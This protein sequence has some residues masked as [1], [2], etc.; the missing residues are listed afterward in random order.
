MWLAQVS[1]RNPVFATMMMMAFV[2]LGLFSYQRLHVDQFPQ[3]DFPVVV[4]TTAYPGAAPE[5]VESEVTRLIEEQVNTI[6]GI[7]NLTS[8]SYEGQSVVII[9]FELTVDSSRAVQDVREKVA[10]VK[11]RFRDE[12]EEPGI[13][14]F[15][16]ADVPIISVAVTSSE[17]PIRELTTL[18]DQVIKKRLENVPGV[19][20]VTLVGG[21]KREIKVALRPTQMQ[22]LGISTDQVLQAIRDENAEYPAGTLTSREQEQVVQIEGRFERPADFERLVVGRR[23][24]QAVYLGQ[25][26]TVTDGSQEQETLALING[27][28]TLAFDVLKAQDQN[29]I[30]VADGIKQ[31]VQSLQAELGQDVQMQVI[32]DAS[33]AIRVGVSNVQRTLIEGA[34]LT[35]IIVFLFLNSW[36]STVITG[37]TLP[38]S[39]IGTFLF[40]Y[41]FGFTLNMLTLMALSLCV[42]LLIDDAIVVRENIVRHAHMGKSPKQAAED[43]TTEI[44]LAVL[45][46]T[47]SIVAVFLPVGFMGGIIGRFFFQFGITVAAA[48]LISLF[49]SF[50]LDPMLSSIWPDPASHGKTPGGPIGR[51]LARFAAFTDAITRFYQR[52]LA[53]SLK[54]RVATVLLAVG[55]FLGSFALVPLL[56]TE[57]LPQGHYAEGVVQFQTPVGSSLEYTESKAR[58][59]TDA[60]REFPEVTYVYAT[61]NAGTASGKNNANAFLQLKDREERQRGLLELKPLIRER[62]NRING[63][64]VTNVGSASEKTLQASLQGPNLDELARYNALVQERLKTIPG[65]VDLD[66]SLKPAKP[67]IAVRIKREAAADVGVGVAQ[68][69]ALLRPLLAGDA[70][71]AWRGPDDEYYDVNVRLDKAD[72]TSLDDLMQLSVATTQLDANG[73]PR[74]VPLRQIADLVPSVGPSQIN[75]RAL[76]REVELTA[77]VQG[78]SAG[79]VANDVAAALAEIPWQPGYHAT[80]GGSTRDMQESFGYA[81]AALG[82]AVVFI[83]MI[84]A[85]QFGSFLQP[86]AIMSSLPLTLIGVFASLLLFGSTLNILSIIGFIMLMG[87]VTKNA[88]L[89]IDFINHARRAG[90]PRHDAILE[91]AKVRLRPILMTTLAMIFGMVPLALGLGEGSEQSAPMGQAVI[92]GIITSSVLTLVV[93]PVIY[94]YLDDFA[95]RWR[96][97][98]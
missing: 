65:L 8:R 31:A 64:T 92:G 40:M 90:M 46:T 63:V 52:L 23:G 62:L 85:S 93:V 20:Q 47:F 4:V 3:I 66:S 74:T 6:S 95:A 54:H 50:T 10:V 73:A 78:R 84:L 21:I 14:R 35:V 86:L 77:N 13:S 82:L 88:I 80:I 53:W 51:V 39:I 57:F 67:T 42:G 24:G 33:R 32:K 83:Y 34:V 58:Q 81:L 9:E 71:S 94:T 98:E 16:P 59:V 19:G 79:D 56:G 12:I 76:N 68:V 11:P 91:A 89:L 43:G 60:L 38:I 97:H 27:Q 30:L 75:R 49:V 41:I 25:I 87:L 26:A 18:A 28:R 29:T 45:A 1:I 2:V 96:R 22:A 37:L 70:V 17:R 7:K 5:S 69:A 15:D 55:T 48:V 36:R 61:V 44:G 72:R